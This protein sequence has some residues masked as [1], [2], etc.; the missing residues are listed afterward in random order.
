MHYESV[1]SSIQNQFHWH[2]KLIHVLKVENLCYFKIQNVQG[3]PKSINSIMTL[4]TKH[5]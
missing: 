3:G 1:E 5:F 2:N 4:E